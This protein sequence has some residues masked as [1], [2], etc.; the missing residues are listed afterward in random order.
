MDWKC[1]K[2]VIPDKE[3]YGSLFSKEHMDIGWVTVCQCVLT[4]LSVGEGYRLALT[5]LNVLDFLHT[6]G[7]CR[8]SYIS[9]VDKAKSFLHA[10]S[11]FYFW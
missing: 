9:T 5:D 10:L 3:S 6:V 7:H 4:S 1:L 8:I 11:T 2:H